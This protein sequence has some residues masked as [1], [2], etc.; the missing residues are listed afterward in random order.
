M[1]VARRSTLLALLVMLLAQAPA[2]GPARAQAAPFSQVA[3]LANQAATG[4]EFLGESVA[5]S[6]DGSTLVIG[7]PFAVGSQRGAVYVFL[8]PASGWMSTAT[9]SAV[10]RA[11]DSAPLD[12]LGTSVAVSA[13]G[14][15]IIAGAPGTEEQ[16]GVYLWERPSAGWS[17]TLTET[18]KLVPSSDQSGAEIGAS[19]ALNAS[20]TT[21]VGGAPTAGGEAGAIFVWEQPGVSW[22]RGSLPQTAVL[23]VNDGGE[24][25]LLG[26]SVA[27]SADGATLLAGAPESSNGAAPPGAGYLFLRPGSNWTTTDQYTA[28][29]TTSDVS[30]PFLGGAVAL[31]GDGAVAALL[32][33]S[34]NSSGPGLAAIYVRPSGGW[35]SASETAVLA[36]P[37][38]ARAEEA[39]VALNGDGSLV[40]WGGPASGT[41]AAG[42]IGLFAR[43][44]GGW[45]GIVA[46]FQV[47]GASDAAPSALFGLATALTP[48]GG[49]VVVGAPGAQSGRGQ[50]YLFAGAQFVSFSPVSASPG[51]TVTIAGANLD[52]VTGVTF[53]GVP[54]LQFTATVS[55]VRAVVGLGASGVVALTTPQGV[56]TRPGFTFVPGPSSTALVALAPSPSA[57]GAPVLAQFAVSTALGLPSGTVVVQASSGE[58]CSAPVA[59]GGCQLVFTTV[60]ARSVSAS[61]QGAAA[62]A[63]STSPG[64]IHVVQAPTTVVLSVPGASL[65]GETIA[66]TFVVSSAMGTPPGTVTVRA[67]TG[68]QCSAPVSVGACSLTFFTTGDRL[69]TASYG[70]AVGYL[71]SVSAPA[72]ESVRAATQTTILGDPQPDPSLVGAPVTISYTVLSAAGVPTGTVIV[73]A[74]T[75]E[76]CVAS[77]AAGGCAMLFA[78]A[79]P[80]SVTAAYVGNEHYLASASLPVSH[81]VGVAPLASTTTTITSVVPSPSFVGRAVTVTYAVTSSA[82]SPAG[83]VLVRA[84]TGEGC[85]GPAPAG[86]CTLV[87]ASPGAR[88]VAASYL[89]NALFAADTSPALRHTVLEAPPDGLTAGSTAPT[90]LG[91]PTELFAAA[92]GGPDLV[93]DWTLG[94][95]AVATGAIVTYTYPAPGRYLATVAAVSGGATVTKSVP[96]DIIIAPQVLSTTASAS[97]GTAT[98]RVGA[99]P[100]GAL[101]QLF[102]DVEPLAG[103]PLTTVQGPTLP[104]GIWSPLVVAAP[105]ADLPAG[106]AFRFR[107]RL[108]SLAGV[109]TSAEGQFVTA[110]GRLFAP[111]ALL[112]ASS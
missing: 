70:G 47:T 110:S 36:S 69:L 104:A 86:S 72:L 103:G 8:R 107:V 61:F 63:A 90:R 93:F 27:L 108:A 42:Q 87:F 59:A 15:V 88:R 97:A 31:S 5:I 83:T 105:L 45:S 6:A 96:V 109:A 98:I 29:L 56:L 85:A 26:V 21:V 66:A 32:A 77:V 73:S 52:Q 35:A 39:S 82:G 55:Q 64:R 18:V 51:D 100:G 89:G 19:V 53:G 20:G 91:S 68:E 94:T 111:I 58:T 78:S 33:T 60:G 9:V 84:E 1:S 38:D 16:G 41:T 54:A 23:T 76:G 81:T 65:V 40:V 2:A 7:A 75:G 71:S 49:T 14:R 11:S 92:E 79:G 17:G 43:P 80:R 37:P 28:R 13:N 57:P 10:L 22:G 74:T 34:P 4:P 99:N 102:I 46:P 112:T 95:G 62:F 106:T 50:A 48:D 67:N 24:G 44:A 25:A 30:A 3:I 12:K 101:T